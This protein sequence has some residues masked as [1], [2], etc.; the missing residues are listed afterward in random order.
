MAAVPDYR[1]ITI[2]I[3]EG[4]E[5]AAVWTSIPRY[6][7]RLLK[8]GATRVAGEIQTGIFLTCPEAWFYPRKRR[9]GGV[10]KGNIA[11]LQKHRLQR[12]GSTN[13]TPKEG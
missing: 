11:A 10:G 8:L 1:E 4:E 3:V 7:R 5:V 12:S 9:V 6:A 13:E 2:T